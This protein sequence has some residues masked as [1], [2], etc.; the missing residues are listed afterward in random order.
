MQQVAEKCYLPANKV[1]LDLIKLL[2]ND[3]KVSFSISG[4]ALRSI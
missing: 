2:G 3:F 1:L 4:M